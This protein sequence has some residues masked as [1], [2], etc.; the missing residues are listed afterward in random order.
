MQISCISPKFSIKEI[1]GFNNTGNVC[2]WPA[3]E[4]LS[5]FCLENRSIFDGKSVIELGAG[6]AGLA[7][8]IVAQACNA[9]DVTLTDGNENSV[10][11]LNVIIPENQFKAS[12]T[13]QKLEWSNKEFDKTSRQYDIA[14]CADC[15]FFDEGRTQLMST[16]AKVLKHSGLAILVAPSRSGTFDDFVHLINNET[17]SFNQV[18]KNCQYSKQIWLR[19]QQLISC[20]GSNFDEDKDYPIMMMFT[21]K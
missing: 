17:E 15:L 12:V 13:A 4:C 14:I 20:D 1:N 7:G 8:L 18:K 6:M 19:R 3:E 9:T 21:R 2:I 11:N 16:L 5:I 10:N